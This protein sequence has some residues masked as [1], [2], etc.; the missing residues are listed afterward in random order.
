MVRKA[1]PRNVRIA[2]FAV[3]MSVETGVPS[4]DILTGASGTRLIGRSGATLIFFTEVTAIMSM[5]CPMQLLRRR[6]KATKARA[7]PKWSSLRGTVTVVASIPRGWAFHMTPIRSRHHGPPI[8]ARPS[9]N[10]SLIPASVR[11]WS[12]SSLM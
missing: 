10:G 5:H 9:F 2:S 6:I 4:F 3:S 1:S 7:G 8:L 12:G 11:F